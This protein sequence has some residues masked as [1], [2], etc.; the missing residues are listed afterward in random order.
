MR[1]A[2][3]LTFV[4]FLV[5]SSPAVAQPAA[6]GPEAIRRALLR[7]ANEPTVEAV[8]A[9]ALAHDPA[10]PA[11][12]ER[13]ARRARRASWLPLLRLAARHVQQRDRTDY[14]DPDDQRTNLGADED[15]QLEARMDFHLGRLVYAPDEAAWGREL[16]TREAD[17]RMRVRQ[18]VELYFERRRLLLE[19]DLLGTTDV[20]REV[21]IAEIEA[22]LSAL[23]GGDIRFRPRRRGA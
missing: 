15:F 12:A 1:C 18:V 4:S 17:R 9:A 7:Y 11:A 5:L 22:L 8:V 6:M 3:P 21:R 10:S 16:R 13:A 19:R 14:I 20:A 23:T 2:A